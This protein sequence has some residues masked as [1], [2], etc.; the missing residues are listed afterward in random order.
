MINEKF[1][2][3]YRVMAKIRLLIMHSFLIILALI[4]ILPFWLML[5]V[6]F[7]D[8]QAVLIEGYRLWPV[9]FSLEAYK[10][11]LINPTQL[12]NSY[13]VTFVITITG[14]FI[15]LLI[16][17]MLGYSLSRRQFALRST[18]SFLVFFT[19]LFSAGL[20]PYYILMVK[21]LHLKDNILA[22]IV[23]GLVNPFWVLVLRSYFRGL[24]S[25]LLDAARVDGAN[26]YR[27]FFQIAL[28]LSMPA[29]VTV[30]L[31][32]ILAY[33]NNWFDAMLFINKQELA[34]LQFMLYRLMANVKIL[35][36]SR[37]MGM[38]PPG[39]VLP[40]LPILT[41]RMA[42]AAVAAIPVAIV[43]TFLQRYFVGGLTL[44]A[45]RGGGDE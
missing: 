27:I 17:A 2:N 39:V 7:S 44:G 15:G 25:E 35:E 1:S 21:Y 31:F 22:L 19:I 45:F 38:L 20:V 29:L 42:L 14:T 30:G 13:A 33:W 4:F 6:S 34:P 36:D 40:T 16:T 11:L 43:F 5:S 18:F 32:Y 41:I 26:E 10:Y 28:P 9:K 8:S 24:P 3:K 37:A 23:P 12:I